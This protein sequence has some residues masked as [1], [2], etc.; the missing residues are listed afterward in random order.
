MTPKICRHCDEEV[1]DSQAV[2]A[3]YHPG[4]SGPAHPIW[5]HPQHVQA[6]QEDEGA[7]TTLLAVL[8]AQTRTSTST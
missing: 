7:H 4:N 8:I 2:L 6:L 5:A 3:G 1:D